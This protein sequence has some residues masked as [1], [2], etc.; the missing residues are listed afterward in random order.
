M[1]PSCSRAEILVPVSVP[2]PR[3]GAFSD[4]WVE[5]CSQSGRVRWPVS[6][7]GQ[8]ASSR[9]Q[10][11][12]GLRCQATQSTLL[13]VPLPRICFPA[14]LRSP[15]WARARC[16][17]VELF[18]LICPL[19]SHRPLQTEGR[20]EIGQPAAGE[21]TGLPTFKRYVHNFGAFCREP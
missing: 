16:L 4:A 13:K 15:G 8:L 3:A 11:F 17:L 1:R 2:D 12:C 9:E 7:P 18:L 6:P 19:T 5:A 14:R 21:R 10:D 20:G